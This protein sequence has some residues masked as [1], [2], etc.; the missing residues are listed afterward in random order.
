ML[1]FHF[2]LQQICLSVF[3]A[4]WQSQWGYILLSHTL[5]KGRM[6]AGRNFDHAVIMHAR[7]DCSPEFAPG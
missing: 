2:F 1:S 5:Q 7:G 6:R 4:N 3:T